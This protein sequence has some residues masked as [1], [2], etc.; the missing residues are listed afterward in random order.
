MAKLRIMQ[1]PARFYPFYGG[2]E[3]YVFEL[4]K[5]LVGLGKARL[6]GERGA[7]AVSQ[8]FSWDSIARQIIEAH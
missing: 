8:E 5:K 1:T 6:M 3:K 2:V 7:V 4:S